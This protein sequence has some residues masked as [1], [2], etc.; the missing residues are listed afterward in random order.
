MHKERSHSFKGGTSPDL[1]DTSTPHDKDATDVF[2]ED[3][4]HDFHYKTLSW[5]VCASLTMLPLIARLYVP[6]RFPAND[7][8]DR[9]QWNVVTAFFTGSRRYERSSVVECSGD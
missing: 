3:P 9:E 2:I 7:S 8:G 5:Q 6:V 1:P 4:D